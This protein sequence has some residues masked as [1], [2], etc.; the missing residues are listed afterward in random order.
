MWSKYPSLYKAPIDLLKAAGRRGRSG[1][2]E[3]PVSLVADHNA[4]KALTAAP[5]TFHN[6]FA[7]SRAAFPRISRITLC[8]DV[9]SVVEWA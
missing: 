7:L 8:E 2:S 3:M 4:R 1:G 6:T 5:R 9:L